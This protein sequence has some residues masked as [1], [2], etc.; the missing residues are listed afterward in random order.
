[1]VKK[2]FGPVHADGHG[3][4]FPLDRLTM[5]L[6]HNICMNKTG[7]RLSDI[8]MKTTLIII[9]LYAHILVSGCSLN[10]KSD[11]NLAQLTQRVDQ[12]EQQVQEISQL[13][14]PMKAQQAINNRRKAQRLKLQEKLAKYREK[15]TPEQLRDAESMYQVANQKWG[16]PEATES[17]KAMIKKYP[18]SNRAGCATLY[19]AQLSQGDERAKYL[20]DCIQKYDDCFYGDGVLVGAYARFL[21]S[22]D[23]RSNDEEK[24]AEALS[25]EIKTKYADAIDHSGLLLVDSAGIGIQVSIY[26]EALTIIH[27]LPDTPAF[28][29]GL[30]SGIVI[31]KIDGVPTA[32]K[33]ALV[34]AAMIRG[35]AGTTVK[36]ELVDT[37]HSKTNTVE[38]T[39]AEF[40]R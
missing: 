29:A 31:Q 7:C 3:R 1:V 10:Q 13:V 18:D 26:H 17:L 4:H 2:K 37:E 33:N 38:L 6:G 24:K 35:V 14:E 9:L 16:S 20:N 28:R 22:Q 25:D 23:Y 30:T 19:L 11:S 27:I 39:R 34:C 21:L 36:L 12:L 5:M 40:K 15:Y 32:G 8:I